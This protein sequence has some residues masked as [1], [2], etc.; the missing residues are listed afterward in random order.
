[1]S[2]NIEKLKTDIQEIYENVKLNNDGNVAQYIPQLASVNPR[3]FGISICTT[4][5]EIINI[6]DTK[7]QFCLQSCSKVLTYLLASHLQNSKTIHEHVGHEPSGKAF[8]DFCF[9]EDNL[10]HNPMINS[11]AI[12]MISMI[13]PNAKDMSQRYNL[14]QGFIKKMAGHVGY[15]GYDN[16]VYLSER[17]LGYENRALANMMMSSNAFP[18]NTKIDETLDLYFQTC[19]ITTNTETG[20]IMAATIANSGVCPV[21]GE[22]VISAELVQNCLTLMSTCGM[23]DFSGCFAFEVGIPAKS[24]VSGCILLSIPGVAG[25]CIWS[26]PLDKKGNSV[27]GVEV[28]RQLVNRYPQFHT[29]YNKQSAKQDEIDRIDDKFILIQKLIY[30]ASTGDINKINEILTKTNVKIDDTDYDGRS[31]LHLA[32]AEG[33]YDLVKYL[34][35]KGAIVDIKDRFGNTPFS[36]ATLHKDKSES[37]Q[38]ICQYLD[39]IYYSKLELEKEEVASVTFLSGDSGDSGDSDDIDAINK[40]DTSLESKSFSY[41]QDLRN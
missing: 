33:H 23:Y 17:G 19:S 40:S 26:P 35:E 12:M 38:N 32:A 15:L 18:E 27:R 9:N 39:E 36:E 34:V 6:G 28:A 4:K 41:F 10:P 7:E 1:M 30:N 31:A 29:Y 11:G 20:S 25:I 24:G 21:S 5:G 8:N 14:I 37:Y 3:L 2:L 16:S 13:E 22:T